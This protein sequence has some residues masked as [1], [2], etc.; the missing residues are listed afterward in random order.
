MDG[1]WILIDKSEREAA[2]QK[3]AKRHSVVTELL[4]GSQAIKLTGQEGAV[5]M[6]KLDIYKWGFE[7][8]EQNAHV[9]AN[10]T[11]FDLSQNCVLMPL[12]Q[13]KNE[14]KTVSLRVTQTM[15][16]AQIAKI[17][18]VQVRNRKCP[19]IFYVLICSVI[20]DYN[21]TSYSM[22]NR[23]LWAAFEHHCKQMSKKNSGNVNKMFLFHGTRNTPPSDIY[24][25]E[26]GFDLR[27]SAQGEQL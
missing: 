16:R 20:L 5:C 19:F 21:I 9:P 8:A 22:Q 3:I 1:N 7:K 25:D 10:W 18:R 2:M 11:A 17:E 4:P 27:R 13:N 14:W 24:K 12:D 26:E 6:V 23:Y 15:P